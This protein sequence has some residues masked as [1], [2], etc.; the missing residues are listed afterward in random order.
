METRS[1]QLAMA[2]EFK[3]TLVTQQEEDEESLRTA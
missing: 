1:S 2:L 3:Y